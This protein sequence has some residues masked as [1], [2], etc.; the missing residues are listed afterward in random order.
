MTIWAMTDGDNIVTSFG[1]CLTTSEPAD[2]AHIDGNLH[3]PAPSDVS[4]GGRLIDGVFSARPVQ[5]GPWHTFNPASFEWTLPADYLDKARAMA[6]ERINAAWRAAEQQPFPA[7]GKTFDADDK[8]IQRM[9]GAAQAAAIAKT[10]LGDSL[11]IEWTCADNSTILM[12]ADMLVSMPVLMTQIADGLHKKCRALKDLID[13]A[14]T[15]EQI[16]AVVWT[17]D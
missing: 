10:T 8:A 5:P 6:R 1:Q 12:D 2:F 4:I 15:L 3:L 11:V 7:Y 13:A 17:T 9:F 14:T 16:D